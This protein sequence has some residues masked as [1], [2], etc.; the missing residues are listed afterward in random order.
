MRRGDGEARLLRR[1]P[2]TRDYAD[3]VRR[4]PSYVDAN[5]PERDA[6]EDDFCNHFGPHDAHAEATSGIP[7]CPL[8]QRVRRVYG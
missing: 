1:P 5:G 4:I 7:D 8:N 6:I 3:N 2:G